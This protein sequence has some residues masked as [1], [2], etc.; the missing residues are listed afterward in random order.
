MNLKAFWQ[1]YLATLP[2]PHAHRLHSLPEAWS[3]GDS[4]A[5]AD[6]LG[7]LVMEGIKT[8]T[9]S[10]YLGENVLAD[11]GLSIILD[12]N[13]QPLCLVETFEITVRA[14]KDVDADFAYQEGEGDRTLEY[15]RE[16]H[17]NY[18]SRAAEDAGYE[19]SEDMLLSCDRFRVLYKTRTIRK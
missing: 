18:F 3:F 4:A 8:A 17:W 14:Y 11:G 9:C 19:V 5:M 6:K 10:R 12:G 7:K 16:E 13:E 2:E 15:W 1:S